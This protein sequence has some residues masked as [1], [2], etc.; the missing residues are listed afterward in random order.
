MLW[1]SREIASIQVIGVGYEGEKGDQE[2]RIRV[3]DKNQFCIGYRELGTTFP[4]P[5]SSNWG[6]NQH[7][8]PAPFC[9][10]FRDTS[11]CVCTSN[12]LIHLVILC[13]SSP[14]DCEILEGFWNQSSTCLNS[15]LLVPSLPSSN[16]SINVNEIN[17][18]AN[19]LG[20]LH[21]VIVLLSPV[22]VMVSRSVS[23]HGI[24][25]TKGFLSSA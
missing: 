23:R 9:L 21:I 4:G 6:R 14:I 3:G 11:F 13:F 20:P 24:S 17:Q 16:C 2:N 19:L 18:Q 10:I 12:V 1:E 15:C 25:Q 22:K 5:C 7:F 8:F